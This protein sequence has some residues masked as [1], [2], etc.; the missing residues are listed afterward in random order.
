[1]TSDIIEKEKGKK[2][3]LGRIRVLQMVLTNKERVVK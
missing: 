1:V 3:V 2:Y